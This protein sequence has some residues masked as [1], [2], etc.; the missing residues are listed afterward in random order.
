MRTE[1]QLVQTNNVL[2]FVSSWKHERSHFV[3]DKNNYQILISPFTRTC[4]PDQNLA[5]LFKFVVFICVCSGFGNAIFN[6]LHRYKWQ[7]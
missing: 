6:A 5:C 7:C 1:Q 4:L 2:S 3:G